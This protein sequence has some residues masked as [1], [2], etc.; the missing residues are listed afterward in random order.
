ML[1]KL[2]QKFQAYTASVAKTA[3]RIGLTP[4]RISVI[5]IAFA[6]LS[7]FAYWGQLFNQILLI[8]API[9]L[10]VSGFFDA[11]DGVV[12]RLYGQ[13]TVFG[14]FLDS[15]LDRYGDALI[16]AGIILGGLCT[17]LQWGLAWG[18]AALI[19]SLLVSYTRARGEAAGV[20]ME[21]V[22]L[23]E[24]AERIIILATASFIAIAW[25]EAQALDWAIIILAIL[26]NLTVLQRAYY[27]YKE[28]KKKQE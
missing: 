2:K 15:L 3:H 23:A 28:S 12:A 18:L 27:F 21:A 25:K 20:K 7:A 16:F 10:L 13:T 19:G 14:G 26:T 22:G 5:G 8:A 24:R 4:N 17:H 9:F 6:F 11:L 1:T